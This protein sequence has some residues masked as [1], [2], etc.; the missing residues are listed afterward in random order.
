MDLYDGNKRPL[1]ET[2][3]R[4]EKT[5][6]GTYTL[7]VHGLLI[8]DSGQVLSQKRVETKAN[9]P[10]KWDLSCSGA[11]KAGETSQEALSREFKEELGLDLNLKTTAPI[12]TASYQQGLSD[13]YLIPCSVDLAG[14]QIAKDEIQNVQWLDLADLFAYLDQG[15]FVP[16]QKSFLQALFDI[17]QA[18][19]EILPDWQLRQETI[20]FFEQFKL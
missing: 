19:S 3:G 9:W 5:S 2:I 6:P 14:L 12:L 11:V 15:R 16:Y 1:G 10:G 17:Y 18:G 8:N 13:Y 7:M 4:Q 20:L